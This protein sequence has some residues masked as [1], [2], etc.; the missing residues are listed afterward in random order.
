MKYVVWEICNM[1][2]MKYEKYEYERM[3]LTG[4]NGIW[5]LW[6]MTSCKGGERS[7][8]ICPDDDTIAGARHHHK[9]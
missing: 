1:I 6:D 4:L 7:H 9:H 3:C 5:S 8:W 2:N